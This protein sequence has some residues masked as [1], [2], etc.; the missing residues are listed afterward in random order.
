[1]V[2]RFFYICGPQGFHFTRKQELFAIK[3]IVERLF[4]KAI[5]C[6]KKCLF[7]FIPDS[8]GKHPIK[9]LQAFFFPIIISCENNF[10]IGMRKECITLLL[11]FFLQLK[12]IVNLSI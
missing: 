10:S 5:A 4:T 7:L 3:K 1:M 12:V 9:L 6:S 8:K 11:Q 2:D